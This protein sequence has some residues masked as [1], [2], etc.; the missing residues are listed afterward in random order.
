MRSPISRRCGRGGKIHSF[1]AM[2][3]LRM[4][5]WSVPSIARHAT[6]CRSA[7][8]RKNANT[9]GAGPVDR[10]RHVMS[11]SGMPSKS[12]SKSSSESVGHAAPADLALGSRVVGVETHQG[13]HVER[14]REPAL[15]PFEEE[16]VA[17]VRLGGRAEP[18]ELTHRPETTAVHRRVD[19]SGE[20][21]GAGSPSARPSSRSPRRARRERGRGAPDSA[22]WDVAPGADAAPPR[23][24]RSARCL[25][26]RRS[27]QHSRG[28]V[29]VDPPWPPGRPRRVGVAPRAPRP[30]HAEARRRESPPH[31]AVG[32]GAS[33]RGPARRQMRAVRPDRLPQLVETVP[34]DGRGREH[35]RVPVARG[36]QVEHLPQLADDLAARPRGPLCSRRRRRRPRGCPPSPSARR[37]PCRA[38]G[39]RP[40]CRS[41]RPRRPPPA[42]RRPSPP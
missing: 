18:R 38:R 39:R 5:V 1:C 8:A 33:S 32:P 40:R 27:D 25:P 30:P 21:E 31:A 3:S 7:A 9:I 20:G 42:P 26:C 19:P 17:G 29:R 4:S 22:V 10:H 6:P 35:R 37:H 34:V 24:P 14:D 11:P 36:A 28:P 12:V 13:R 2:Y 41:P 15:S 23:A 16:P